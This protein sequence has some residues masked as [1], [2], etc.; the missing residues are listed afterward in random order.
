[1]AFVAIRAW[2]IINN[3]VG[4][5]FSDLTPFILNGM[6]LSSLRN[7]LL[8]QY[9]LYIIKNCNI[10]QQEKFPHTMLRA[11]FDIKRFQFIYIQNVNRIITRIKY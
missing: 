1:M 9:Y 3:W 10:N 7:V 4:Y 11:P 5:T 6:Y 2:Y 8:Q